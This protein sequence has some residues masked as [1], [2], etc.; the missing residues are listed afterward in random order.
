MISEE[1][2]ELRQDLKQ[3]KAEILQFE[4]DLA[5]NRVIDKAIVV[6]RLL[7]KLEVAEAVK[8]NPNWANQPRVPKEQVGG[9]RWTRPGGGGAAGNLHLT[10]GRGRGLGGQQPHADQTVPT[11]CVPAKL[12]CHRTWWSRFRLHFNAPK[13]P[14]RV[15]NPGI[16]A[17]GPR[18]RFRMLQARR[19]N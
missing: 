10:G 3:L 14:S 2:N 17:G 7:R 6:C 5:W 13:Q 15:L 16:Q 19:N 11:A 4:R 12:K 1:L 8:F 18:P 9:G